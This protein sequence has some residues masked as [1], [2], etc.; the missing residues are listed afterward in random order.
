[1]NEYQWA[2]DWMPV[3]DANVKD[4][5]YVDWINANEYLWMYASEWINESMYKYQRK[6]K[7]INQWTSMKE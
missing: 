2:N 4:W 6:N 5:M 3:Y 1:M 7:W